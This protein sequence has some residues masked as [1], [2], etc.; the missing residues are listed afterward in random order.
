MKFFILAILLSLN[1]DNS[2]A[3][4]TS[5]DFGRSDGE[6]E[7]LSSKDLRSRLEIL[8]EIFL[9]NAEGK[10]LLQANESRLWKFGSKG[11]II[12]NWSF[13]SPFFK[14]VALK[15]N[16]KLS[17]DGKV[18]ITIQQFDSMKR[19]EGSRDVVTGK[20]IREK[21]FELN[22]FSAI[23]WVAHETKDEKVIVR[24][25]PRLGEKKDLIDVSNFPI[26]LGNPI[27]YD[28]KGQLWAQVRTLEGKYLAFKTH[29]GQVALSYVPF[30]GAKEIGFVQ[31]SQI[32]I[33]S[34]TNFELYIRSDTQIVSTLLPVK[35]YGLLNMSKKSEAVTSV[36]S[37]SS[38][39]EKD[40]L[41]HL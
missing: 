15:Q 1:A 32:T 14:E 23:S 24:L 41:E 5:N 6:K 35:I 25:T 9:T 31:G 22:D 28:S 40:F 33:N 3:E 34:E 39:K 10:L 36:L 37:S 38:S 19:K 8:G 21:Q 11:D 20:L 2:Y 29:L 13:S 26:T 30:R 7:I 4:S 27:V 12:S 16:W 18:T 17:E